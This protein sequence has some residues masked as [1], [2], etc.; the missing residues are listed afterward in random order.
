MNGEQLINLKQVVEAT[1]QKINLE[2]CTKTEV[3]TI[4]GMLVEKE[5]NKN[6][7]KIKDFEDCKDALVQEESVLVLKYLQT[8]MCNG[9]DFLGCHTCRRLWWL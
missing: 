5:L 8:D 7:G 2:D 1:E 6:K 4:V 9:C 3:E